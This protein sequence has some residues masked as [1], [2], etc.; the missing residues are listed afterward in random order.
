[1]T[2]QQKTSKTK[3]NLPGNFK[4]SLIDYRKGVEVPAWNEST[5]G[6]K[7]MP[8]S[9]GPENK[10]PNTLF[11]IVQESV[12]ASSIINGTVEIVKGYDIQLNEA[13]HDNGSLYYWPYVNKDRET[14]YDLVEN[15]TRD[16]VMYG[17]LSIQVIYNKLDQ[18]AELYHMPVEYI[19]LN[20]D[21]S[22]VFFSKKHSKY[23]SNTL[24]YQAFDPNNIIDHKSQI[25]VYQ[26]SGRRQVYGISSLTPCVYDMVAEGLASKYV[27][28]SLDNGLAARYIISLPNAQTLT[29]E[30]KADIEEAISEKFTGYE[31]AGSFMVYYNC[32]SDGFEVQRID[33]DNSHEIFESITN[34]ASLKIYKALHATPCL[35]GDPSHSTGFSENEYDM[36]YMIYEKMT[37]K[38]LMNIISNSINDILGDG[39]LKINIQ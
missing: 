6:N 31:N 14:V 36:S 22:T 24:K 9:W 32:G 5:P 13:I 19:R 33:S 37:I 4:F 2:N 25:Y 8:V 1:M 26:N 28:T 12:T 34:A 30:Q 16:Y 21:R 3:E 35:F 17:M 18:I 7:D 10:F 20:E 23:S 11:Q 38:P 29:D 27:K 39:S 15:L